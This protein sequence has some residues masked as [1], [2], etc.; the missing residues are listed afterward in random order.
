MDSDTTAGLMTSLNSVQPVLPVLMSPVSS[1]D[2]LPISN[3]K[4]AFGMTG[5]Y[6]SF[7]QKSK[8]EFYRIY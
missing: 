1:A 3:L 7:S 6:I 5:R 4:P 2:A 8:D